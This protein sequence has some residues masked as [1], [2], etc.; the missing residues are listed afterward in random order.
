MKS[1]EASINENSIF[2]TVYAVIFSIYGMIISA[3]ETNFYFQ[4]GVSFIVI[5]LAVSSY[6]FLDG[7]FRRRAEH[8]THLIELMDLLIERKRE[9]KDY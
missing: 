7:R 5:L 8:N 6:F 4:V 9:L 2:L 3:P 1:K